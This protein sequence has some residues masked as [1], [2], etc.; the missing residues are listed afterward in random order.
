MQARVKIAQHPGYL[1]IP[2]CTAKNADLVVGIL[3]CHRPVAVQWVRAMQNLQYPAGWRTETI[4]IQSRPY[5]SEARG[6]YDWAA[7]AASRH[8]IA[9]RAL[10]MGA[11]YL[12]FVD[13]DV[14]LPRHAVL[15]LL[16]VLQSDER[17]KACSGIYVDKAQPRG[18]VIWDTKKEWID[19]EAFGPFE[20]GGSGA[21]CL[22]I[23]TSIFAL[24]PQPYFGLGI[25]EDEFFCDA[26]RHAGYQVYAHGDVQC[27]HWEVHDK[28]SVRGCW[29]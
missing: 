21:G 13:D 1:E 8:Q 26:V 6:G 7:V 28:G 3:C 11:Q 19:Q 15:T 22:L 14:E 2:D 29:R 24:I 16:S 20:I 10:R 23:D 4:A 27:G 17:I 9:E 12:L 18:P 25:R 5:D